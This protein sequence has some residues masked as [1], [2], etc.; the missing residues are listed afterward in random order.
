[1]MTTAR[2]TIA[3]SALFFTLTSSAAWAQERYATMASVDMYRTASRAA[4]I[5]FAR[6][7]APPSI[8]EGAE[9]LVLGQAG[10][11]TAVKGGNGFTC[12]VERSWFADFDDSEFWNPK[13][14][15]PVC[16]N[17]A[18]T[19]SVVPGYL[20]RTQWV[21]SGVPRTELLRRTQAAV[22]AKK[23]V[24]P[25]I[26]AMCFMQSKDGYL[27]DKVGGHWHP[28][29]MFYLPRV[30]KA[31]WGAESKGSPIFGGPL[32]AE[33]TSLFVVPVLDWSDGSPGP[34]NH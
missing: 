10:Y 34:M 3:A 33:P 19:R 32:L 28:H 5:A 18:A 25:E 23:I 20:E 7:A 8:S 31:D 26:G 22:V 6:S 24:A 14:R 21:L 2:K 11:E 4:E 29:L 16:F 17:P 1:M 30:D 27:G 12:L 9:I 15:A 13:I